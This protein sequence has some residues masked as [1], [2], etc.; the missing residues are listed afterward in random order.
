MSD[1]VVKTI[2]TA[3][4]SQA[5][6]AAEAASEAT[7]KATKEMASAG[8]RE[9]S[10]AQPGGIN[11]PIG[12]QTVAQKEAAAA[13]AKASV[14]IKRQGAEAVKAS[15]ATKAY[16]KT[17][18]SAGDA[19]SRSSIRFGGL[20]R[21][22]SGV[23]KVATAAGAAIAV[24]GGLAMGIDAIVNRAEDARKALDDLSDSTD[25]F[26][27]ALLMTAQQSGLDDTQKAIADLRAKGQAEIEALTQKVAES[28]K[29]IGGI[30]K[31]AIGL[32]PS[33]RKQQAEAE[34]AT[35]QLNEKINRAQEAI[36]KD[37]RAKRE[38][39]QKK[40]Q[41]KELEEAKKRADALR[42]QARELNAS[43]IED[44]RERA[45]A[46][47]QL[48]A[49]NNDKQLA[50]AKNKEE[51][52]ALFEIRAAKFAEFQSK[53][54][55]IQQDELDKQNEQVKK[56]VEFQVSMYEALRGAVESAYQA[57]QQFS[58]GQFSFG[59]DIKAIRSLLEVRGGW[60]R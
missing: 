30:L 27:D 58:E 8:M 36:K 25:K 6:A 55:K 60:K 50:E 49:E 14:E 45:A 44:A 2:F 41:E 59:S 22:L 34:R 23:K 13:A 42:Q 35:K 10:V 29:S 56:S 3:D 7:R 1:N 52:A 15:A 32:G 46:E 43:L 28:Q 54:T 47:F 21:A 18:D 17:L 12:R 57:Q 9:R 26:G 39:E 4:A 31:N 38:A 48:F 11:N 19:A 40:E 51:Q 24:G 16:A 20:T 37:A 53:M 33:I 5:I